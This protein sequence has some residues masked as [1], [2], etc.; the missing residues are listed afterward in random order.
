M[1]ED[2]DEAVVENFKAFDG[3]EGDILAMAA[4]P[5]RQLLAT[6]AQSSQYRSLCLANTTSGP[7]P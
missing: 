7:A 4:Y 3:H 6:G 2:E 1:W 5:E